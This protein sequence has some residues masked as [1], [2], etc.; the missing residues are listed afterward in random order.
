MCALLAAAVVAKE[1]GS[2]LL[3]KLGLRLCVRHFISS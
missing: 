2:F 3:A 1:A